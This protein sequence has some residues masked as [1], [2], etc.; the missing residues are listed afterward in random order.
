VTLFSPPSLDDFIYLLKAWRFWLLGALLGVLLGAAVYTI[1]PPPYRARATVNVDFNLEEA[2]P[3]DTDR[4]QFYY[5]EREARKLEEIAW[6]DIVILTVVE[7]VEDK[8]ISMSVLRNEKLLLSQPAEGGWH[9]YA[10][11]SDPRR[12]ARLATNWANAFVLY[13]QLGVSNAIEL[14]AQKD[15]LQKNPN[16]GA[17]KKQIAQLE[18][19]TFGVNP[20]VQVKLVQEAEIPPRRSVPLSAYLLTGTVGVWF[21]SALV[22]LFFGFGKK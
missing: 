20:Y 16:D 15:L 12:A 17:V 9:F 18:D 10:D 4:Q 14:E 13:T 6:S 1:M 22:V 19:L 11:D 21:V 7:S 5:L 8:D 2:W 3:Q